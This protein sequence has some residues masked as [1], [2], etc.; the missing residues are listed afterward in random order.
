MGY[1]FSVYSVDLK[2]LRT[3]RGSK[4]ARLAAAIKKKQAERFTHADDWFADDIASGAPSLA[5]ALDELIAGK[6][7]K[8]KYGFQYGYAIELLCEHFGKRIDEGDLSSRID[9]SLDPLLAKAKKPTL[10][11]LLRSGVFPLAIP[12]PRDFPEIGTIDAKAMTALGSALAAIEPMIPPD[13]DEL[14]VA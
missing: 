8:K 2:K 9:E 1:G 12:E 6:P 3:A 13:D 4:N 11:K 10:S 5:T 7:T 14:G